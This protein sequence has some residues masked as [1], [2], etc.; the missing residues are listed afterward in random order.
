MA[1]K[2]DL[3]RVFRAGGM[4]YRLPGASCWFCRSEESS[5][6][7]GTETAIT[8]KNGAMDGNSDIGS[9]LTASAPRNTE[10]AIANA[11]PWTVF[12]NNTS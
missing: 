1:L 10:I 3:R 7:P 4:R 2:P 5:G 8:T 9:V 12:A 6:L 11:S